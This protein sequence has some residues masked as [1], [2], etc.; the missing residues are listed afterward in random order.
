MTLPTGVQAVA[1]NNY[2]RPDKALDYLK[3]MTRTFGY[4][5]P[6]SIYEVSPDFGMMTQAWNL[7]SY[8]IPIV[9]QFFGIQRIQRS[10]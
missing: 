6:G 3:R 7:Y 2:G 10:L 5:L 4:A 1:E 8:A 9:G